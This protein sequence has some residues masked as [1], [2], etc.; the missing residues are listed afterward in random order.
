MSNSS[1]S[2]IV[3]VARL[4]RET[5]ATRV[6]ASPGICKAR[7]RCG[8]KAPPPLNAELRLESTE[9]EARLFHE[10]T[11]VAEAKRSQLNLQ[12]PPCPSFEE[13][14]QAAQS[15]IGFKGH[16]FPGC[17]VRRPERTGG[18]GLCIFPGSLNGTSTFAAPW[19]PDLSLADES[20]NVK[21]EFLW[22]ALDCTG[23]FA[24]FPL[25]ET[26]SSFWVNWPRPSWKSS[27]QGNVALSSAGLWEW[28]VAS[29][30]PAP[31][32]MDRMA[33]SQPWPGL[34]GSKY[35]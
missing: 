28:K 29:I 27:S 15:F 24:L 22:S 19:T 30:S 31:P 35:L 26:S 25:P 4:D 9:D 10:A 32:F 14:E 13:A 1:K 12:A 18:D 16:R 34:S 6:A 21:P 11:L 2:T 8:F 33:A 5:A 17:F 23:A 3:S 20:G 7:L